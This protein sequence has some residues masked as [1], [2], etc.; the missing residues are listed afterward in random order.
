[1]IGTLLR[2]LRRRRQRRLE[3]RVLE[4]VRSRFCPIAHVEFD[5]FHCEGENYTTL[6]IYIDAPCGTQT[7][8][9]IVDIAYE[10]AH[11]IFADTDLGFAIIAYDKRP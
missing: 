8:T 6:R 5:R 3:E 4:A 1:M 7:L 10:I 9:A 2:S 11:D